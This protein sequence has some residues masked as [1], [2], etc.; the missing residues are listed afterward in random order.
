MRMNRAVVLAGWG[1]L[2]CMTWAGGGGVVGKVAK[3]QQDSRFDVPTVGED[4]LRGRVAVV[5]K[6]RAIEADR[7]LVVDRERV[8]ALADANGITIVSMG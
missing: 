3:R 4:T 5:A 6:A 2:C 7:T 8:A 1:W